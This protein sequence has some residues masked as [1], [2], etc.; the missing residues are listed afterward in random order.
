ML[1]PLPSRSTVTSR[2][3]SEAVRAASQLIL[4]QVIDWLMLM[5]LKEGIPT[6]F[7]GF[8]KNALS[9]TWSFWMKGLV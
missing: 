5:T 4:L 6:E 7:F 1:L 8:I 2:T 9:L 3:P